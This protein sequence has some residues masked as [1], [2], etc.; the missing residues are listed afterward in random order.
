MQKGVLI[1]IILKR[2]AYKKI[3]CSLPEQIFNCCETAMNRDVS[4]KDEHEFWRRLLLLQYQ[5]SILKVLKL[6]G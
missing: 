1:F 6:S 2:N 3:H 4:S 5:H